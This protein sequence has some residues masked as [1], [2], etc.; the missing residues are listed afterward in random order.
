MAKEDLEKIKTDLDYA[1]DYQRSARKRAERVG[2]KEGAARIKEAEE[3][4]DEVRKSFDR[5]M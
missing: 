1:K 5:D 2:D 3:K 4:N